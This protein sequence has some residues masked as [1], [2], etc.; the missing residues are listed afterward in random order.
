[1]LTNN[2]LLIQAAERNYDKFLVPT[3]LV[4]AVKTKRYYNNVDKSDLDIKTSVN[5]IGEIVNL[6]QELNTLFW[7]NLHNGETFE[8]NEE[9]YNDIVKLAILSNVE[10]DKAKKEY[11]LDSTQE[12]AKLKEKYLRL[13]NK[14]RYIKPN[15]FGH[16]AR[17][18]GYYNS[19]RKNYKQHHTTMDYVQSIIRRFRIPR[20]R[21]DGK[22]NQIPFIEIVDKSLY[23]KGGQKREQI[24]RILSLIRDMSAD[25]K[26]VYS[27]SNFTSEEKYRLMSDIRER[28]T[29]EISGMKIS[30]STMYFLLKE[31]EKDENKDIIM[32]LFHVLFSSK[33]GAFFDMIMSS[34]ESIGTLK[35][36]ENGIIHLYGISYIEVKN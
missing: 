2:Q 25:V 32:P 15:F 1:M 11:Q 30:P 23:K 21:W 8:G 5:K 22:K 24:N 20:L 19:K 16:L 31:L 35:E 36:D 27:N 26:T 12:I 18:K 28:C 10:I 34:K 6:S 14:N 9:L 7:D 29:D 4:E 33:N 13:D 3:S 17:T